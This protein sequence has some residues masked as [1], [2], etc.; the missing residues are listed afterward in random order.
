MTDAQLKGAL[1]AAL[2]NHAL[3]GEV[4]GLDKGRLADA[5][6][7]IADAM[8]RRPAGRPAIRAGDGGTSGGK[9]LSWIAVNTDDMPFLVDSVA[10]VVTAHGLAIE[11][12][13]HPVIDAERD[14][15][16]VLRALAPALSGRPVTGR[17]ESL[18]FIETERADARKRKQLCKDIAAA[19]ADVRAAV[20]DWGAML[21]RLERDRAQVGDAAVRAFLGWLAENNFTF[22]GHS[23]I[24]RDG[25]ETQPPLGVLRAPGARR[26]VEDDQAVRAGLEA[27]GDPARHVLILKADLVSAVHRRT[28]MDVIAL[29]IRDGKGRLTGISTYA[30]LFTSHALATPPEA[31]PLLAE[32]VERLARKL[33]LAPA[34]HAAK[35]LL[36]AVT[37][38]P[39]DLLFAADDDVLHGLAVTAM[40][41]IDRPRPKAMTVPDPLGRHTNVLVWLPRDAFSMRRRE[42]IALLASGLAN[43]QVDGWTAGMGQDALVSLD[44]VIRHPRDARI[45]AP[46]LDAR[47][48]EMIRGWSTAV[49]AALRDEVGA[50]RAARLALAH[51]EGF[52]DA[53]R[54]QF[55]PREAA[56]DIRR[57]AALP[58]AAARDARIYVQPGDAANQLRLKIYRLGEIIP[59]SDAV[60]VLENFGFRVIEEYPF[61]LK[62]EKGGW[63]HDFLLENHND[64]IGHAK[65]APVL[66]A[67]IRDVLAGL[68][69]NDP[70]NALIGDAG[71]DAPSIR[72][73][74][75][76]FRYM[77][78]TGT[79][80]GIQTVVD[81]LGRYPGLTR[82]LVALFA[83]AHDPR[84]RN[85]NRRKRIEAADAAVRAGLNT[86]TAID[87]D[88][89]IRRFL[90]I[91]RATL[92]TN[93][94]APPGEE[95]LA[96]KLDS[97]AIPGLPAP[98]PWREIFV[99]SPRVEGIHLRA[100]PI[101]R[102]G[103]RWSDRRDDFRTEILGLM[104]AQTVK[105]SVIVPTGAKGGFYAKQLPPPV[106]RDAWLAEG[107]EA[108]RIFIRA[109]LSLTDNI[110]NGK[111]VHPPHVVIGDGD[112]PYFVVAA[113]KGTASFS[114]VANAI[115]LDRG[116]WLGDAFASGG[117]H[118]YDHKAMGITA[119]GGWISVTRH[120]AELG[121]DV[122]KDPVTV[123]GVGDM[124]GDVFGNGM[125]LSKAIRLVAA[126][127]HRHIFLDPSPDPA[128][129][130]AERK[131]LFALP[132][133]SWA[134]YDARL[135]S[136]GGGVFPR[137]QKDIP[138]SPQVRALLGVADASLG[139]SALIEAILKAQV[140]LLWFGGI[141]TYIKGSHE[142]NIGVG[143]RAND[144]H[145]VNGRDLRARVVGEGANLG[146]TQAGR[147]EYAS[148]G[149]RI[150][151]DFIDNSAGVDCS[152]NEVNIKIA[153]NAEMAAGHLAF[154]ARNRLL[155]R[156]TDD[157]AALVLEDNRLQT[158]AL[159]LA[160]RGRATALPAYQR[161]IQMLEAQGRLNRAVE[162]LPDDEQIGQRLREGQGLERPELAVLL[163]YAKLA[164]Q[165]A[166]E[167]AAF[168][169][170]PAL[171]PT[172]IAA[173][174]PA[175]AKAHKPAILAHRLR[176]QIIATK[177]ANR[178]I[179]RSGIVMPFALAEEEGAALGHVAAAYAAAELLFDLPSLWC[180]IEEAEVDASAQLALHNAAAEAVQL[181]I[182]DLLRVMAPQAVPGDAAK[183]LKAG[184]DKLRRWLDDLL[185]DSSRAQAEALRAR[186]LALGAPM[187]VVDR[188]VDLQ[189]LDGA[190]SLAKLCADLGRANQEVPMARAYIFLGQT[191]GLDWAKTAAL[192]LSPSDAWER[193]LLAGLVRDF[194]HLRIDLLRRIAANGEEPGK[195][196]GQWLA[197][198]AQRVDQFRALIARAR[199]QPAITPTMLAQISSQARV[200]LGR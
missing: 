61:T 76:W 171:E 137:A 168:V 174:P 200:L 196:A 134:D 142:T 156:M 115:A 64:G 113:D 22:L 18:I 89:I 177:L 51:A 68:A 132:R 13:L 53:Y 101:A 70:F 160:E 25:T 199:L 9:R 82:S 12:L 5:C 84:N 41:L 123:A 92:R 138:L 135:I 143:D 38:L 158:L 131:R 197:D 151:T 33:D 178:I 100:G 170:D 3:P 122:A 152:D 179:N 94:Y 85:G 148:R 55:D 130:W 83:A 73:F 195:A 164:L 153:L 29:P 145:R 10:A 189:G 45:D 43:G 47:L 120:F 109:L 167:D 90:A 105:N 128:K 42:E 98:V 30:G 150:N 181:H 126:F 27:L 111:V 17:R 72:L 69:E 106:N 140:D 23:E 95:A 56:T 93:A 116:F 78:Q 169:T 77:R 37:Q 166:I 21:S 28:R 16:D 86:V 159:S 2:V 103:I 107:T 91:I 87:D 97:R 52:S 157:V 8:T 198:H 57:M 172:L 39:R 80:Y 154:D 99:Y 194:E 65:T 187:A 75:A 102:G 182:A 34:S 4:D 110:A 136:K 117:S 26:L 71:L 15:S 108:Y 81:V 185:R 139:P 163:S 176:P 125:L 58:D 180:A 186:L 190:I 67:A 124:S 119:R 19:L 44:Y 60:P 173:F 88:A 49:E 193:L 79:A 192:A 50:P 24:S 127:D 129:S 40:S 147:V 11:R 146:A 36:H 161:V 188:I 144:A 46:L 59:L 121:V 66:E 175:L 31:V 162:G 191:L 7:F 6:A 14:D 1:A 133:S 118:G 112:D 32:R 155:G 54:S 183:A 96:L 184:V 141:G 63:I 149:G 48:H 104:K 20:R 35:A 114:D 62:G 165:D 74:R